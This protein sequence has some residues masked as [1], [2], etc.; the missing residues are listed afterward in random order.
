M[1]LAAILGICVLLSWPRAMVVWASAHSQESQPSNSSQKGL[2]AQ[3]PTDQQKAPDQ[4]SASPQSP[5]PD[6]PPPCPDNSQTGS[7]VKSDCKPTKATG[8]KPKKHHHKAVAPADTPTESGP[9]K[10]VVRNG[11]TSEPTVDLSPGLSPQQASHQTESTNQ[12]LATSDANLKKIAGRQLNANQ[13][14]TVKQI[15]SYMKQAKDAEKVGDVQR[16]HN[17]AV[18]ASLLSADLVGPE[19]E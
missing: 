4:P 5:A 16:A 12:L 11:G 13:Q 7:S 19:K 10:T 18:K 15:N 6:I 17:L 9:T 8:A 2:A 14:D 1:P 3:P